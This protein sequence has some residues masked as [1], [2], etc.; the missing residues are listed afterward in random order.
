MKVVST[1]AEGLG[2]SIPVRQLKTFL[3]NRDAFAFD[4]RNPNA[5]FR[6]NTPPQQKIN[7][8]KISFSNFFMML[9]M[10]QSSALQ[11]VIRCQQFFPRIH[12]LQLN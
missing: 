11:K 2:F 10:Q 12:Y 7:E 5:G 1:G 4:P 9:H 8:N 6:Y 3:E